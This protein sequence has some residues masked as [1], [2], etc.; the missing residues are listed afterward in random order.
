MK[1]I[2]VIF[3]LFFSFLVSDLSATHIVAGFSS[4]K[5]LTGNSY[6]IKYTLIRDKLSGGAELDQQIVVQVYSFDGINYIFQGNVLT[7]R[8][9]IFQVSHGEQSPIADQS[10]IE[11]EYAEYMFEFELSNPLEDYLFVYQ[12]CCRAPTFSNINDPSEN[13]ITLITT[14]TKEAQAVQNSSIEF[15]NLPNFIA[16]ANQEQM[17]PINATSIDGDTLSYQFAPS[18]YGGGLAGTGTIG[19][20]PS[21][22][23]GV[24]PQGPCYPPYEQVQFSFTNGNFANPFPAWENQGMNSSDGSLLGI[25]AEIGQHAYGFQIH[26]LRNGQIINSTSFD[27]I[28]FVLPFISST[29]DLQPDKL[30]LVGNPSN[31]GFIIESRVEQDLSYE[32]IN[33]KGEKITS[34]V[35]RSGNRIKIDFNGPSGMY[36]LKASNKDYN[37]NLKLIKAN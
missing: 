3:T 36:I 23:D 31:N 30:W 25:P 26:E 34:T 2:I 19:G 37:Q 21:D 7:D 5:H 6:E 10:N 33:L 1:N 12:R 24:T 16:I 11:L 13:G 32:V 29:E 35:E 8:D 17:L 15:D 20:E 22:C 9:G 18:Y 27:Y 28:T 14:I 4:Y